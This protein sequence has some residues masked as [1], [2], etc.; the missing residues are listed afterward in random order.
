MAK[1]RIDVWP[2]GIFLNCTSQ[3][4]QQ[5]LNTAGMGP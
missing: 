2:E 3:I 1:W 4:K 5:V